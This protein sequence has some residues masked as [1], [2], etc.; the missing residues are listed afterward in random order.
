MQRLASPSIFPRLPLSIRFWGCQSRRS[1]R[2]KRWF[3]KRR[4]EAPLR[5]EYP[6]FNLSTL[7]LDLD[8]EDAKGVRAYDPELDGEPETRSA[9]KYRELQPVRER[10]AA[11]E[12][13]HEECESNLKSVVADRLHPLNISDFDLLAVAILGSPEVSR[14][15][16]KWSHLVDHDHSRLYAPILE[17]VLDQN[18]IPRAVRDDTSSTI[19]F[20]LQRREL[21]S[22]FHSPGPPVPD[23]EEQFRLNLSRYSTISELGRLITRMVAT[24]GGCRILSK[25]SDEVHTSLIHGLENKPRAIQLLMLL[26]NIVVNLDRY[27]LPISA[28]LCELGIWTSLQCQAI[29]T[30]HDYLKRRVERGPLDDDSINSILEQLLQGSITSPRFISYGFQFQSNPSSR[31]TMVFSLLTG[32]IPGEDQPAVSLRSLTSRERPHGHHLYIQCLA[33]LG[34]FRTLWHEW[35]STDSISQGTDVDKPQDVASAEGFAE[36][37]HFVKNMLLALAKNRNIAGMASSPEFSWATGQFQKDCQLDMVAISR[38]AN[39]LA[40]PEKETGNYASNSGYTLKQNWIYEIFKEKE[41]RKVFPALQSFL[42][43]LASSET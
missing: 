36:K 43:R 37:S 25:L 31:L 33:R 18:G 4:T 27:G 3:Q 6:T 17:S 15:A 39:L 20:M 9:V 11:F 30:A 10:V 24:Q 7:L 41:A 13:E 23:N 42:T 32:Y 22:H 40:S 29:G 35:H 1:Y 34:A 2:K 16:A 12:K 28:N 14:T 19:P 8:A 5:N 21:A 38:S 26:N